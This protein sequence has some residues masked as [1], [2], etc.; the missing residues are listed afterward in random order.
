MHII[1]IKKW[2]KKE[3][4]VYIYISVDA[5]FTPAIRCWKIL[6]MTLKSYW[7][8]LKNVYESWYY[9][10]VHLDA[11]LLLFSCGLTSILFYLSLITPL[12]EILPSL[13]SVW[14]KKGTMQWW[15]DWKPYKWIDVHFALEQFSGP[16]GN[17]DG[18]LF[19]YY[20][21]YEEK[22]VS[23]KCALGRIFIFLLELN[24]SASGS[25]NAC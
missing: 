9:V 5:Y 23:K 1:V 18:I 16:E 6:K 25:D 4:W 20:N 2:R 22:K 12:T 11:S 3:S 13:Q 8:T 15:R 17:K 7:M 14:V 10:F 19:I 21:F 24:N